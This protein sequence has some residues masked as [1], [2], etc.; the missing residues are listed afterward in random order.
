MSEVLLTGFPGFIGK[1]LLFY[2]LEQRLKD[3]VHLLVHP[4]MLKLAQDAVASQS[5]IQARVHIH[6]GDITAPDLG[7]GREAQGLHNSI[8]VIFH[9]AAIY[10]LTVPESLAKK[11]NVFG[12]Q[13]M[14]NF[15]AL[16]VDLKRFN[17]IS[18]CYVA[19]TSK[20]LFTSQMLEKGQGF[21]NFYESTKHEAEILVQKKM[22]EVPITVFRP[23]IVV[24]DSQTGETD[25]FDGPYVV[26][27]FLHQIRFLLRLVPNLGYSHCEVNTIP[28]DYLVKVLSHLGFEEKAVGKVY[29]VCDQTPPTTEE[30]FEFLVYMMGRFRPYKSSVLKKV[31]LE[32]LRLKF[33][34]KITGITR[35]HLDYFAHEGQFR[36]QNLLKDLEGTDIQLG[37]YQDFYPHLYQ[38]MTR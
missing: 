3:S 13:N 15:A 29:Q 28:V 33:A 7:L 2:L 5:H 34:T 19:G 1:R 12:T 18:T 14:L 24:G 21:H 10:D 17:Y 8:N 11:V 23:A 31:I 27:K 32:I 36:C 20:G 38:F 30:F 4:S 22:N 16:C 37:C 9:L 25:K 6:A 26:M 35:Q